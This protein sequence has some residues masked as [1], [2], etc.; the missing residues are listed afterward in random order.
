MS[1]YHPLV[2]HV[3]FVAQ[4]HSLNVLIGMLIW[5]QKKIKVIISFSNQPMFRSHV[6]ILSKLLASVMSYTNIIPLS[7]EVTMTMLSQMYPMKIETTYPW[8]PCSKRWWLC[9]TVP[10][11]QETRVI[12]GKSKPVCTWPAVSQIWSLIF[13]PLSSMV[14]ILKSIPMVAICVVLKVSSVIL[15]S[16]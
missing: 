6:A 7:E 5:F 14:L 16:R 1:A 13:F 4:D 3:C 12:C 2:L 9:E 11:E 8:H 10:D 15:R